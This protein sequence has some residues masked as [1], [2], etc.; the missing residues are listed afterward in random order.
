MQYHRK[1]ANCR[2][3][4][5]LLQV[6]YT[7]SD[8]PEY[9]QNLQALAERGSDGFRSEEEIREET[10]GNIPCGHG[11]A[12]NSQVS[13]LFPAIIIR[14]RGSQIGLLLSIIVELFLKI[15]YILSSVFL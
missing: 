6:E 7:V 4:H 1:L 14:Y 15:L 10:F 13:L 2:F 3:F 12:F 8:L 9:I 11:V 5:S